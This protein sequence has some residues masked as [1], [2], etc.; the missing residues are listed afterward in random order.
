MRIDFIMADNERAPSLKKGEINW[1]DYN[2]P[3]LIRVMHFVPSEVPADRKFLV[4][5]LLG[6]HLAAIPVCL[7]NFVDNCI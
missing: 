7:L 4:F 3:P 1:H 5:A 2:Y 6:I